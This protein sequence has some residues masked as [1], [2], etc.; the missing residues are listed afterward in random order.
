MTILCIVAWLFPPISP[1]RLVFSLPQ[2]WKARIHVPVKW[3]ARVL[4]FLF[5]HCRTSVKK[6]LFHFSSEF[7]ML[8]STLLTPDM[9]ALGMWLATSARLPCN[10]ASGAPKTFGPDILAPS[11]PNTCMRILLSM[12]TSLMPQRQGTLWKIIRQKAPWLLFIFWIL[13]SKMSS[14]NL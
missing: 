3:Y 11:S 14:Q 6:L 8:G 4:Y 12:P 9:D 1:C 5:Y 13:N 2:C 7:F 10:M